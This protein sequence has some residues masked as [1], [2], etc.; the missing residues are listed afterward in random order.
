MPDKIKLQN[1][2]TFFHPK[3]EVVPTPNL[4]RGREEYNK[5]NYLDSDAKVYAES[6]SGK[7]NSTSPESDLLG[8]LGISTAA[9]A[10]KRGLS[11]L[12]NFFKKPAKNAN[13]NTENTIRTTDF[14]SNFYK[15]GYG[16][17]KEELILP[18]YAKP[19]SPINQSKQYL[20]KRMQNGGLEKVRNK[21]W[22]KES[23]SYYEFLSKPIDDTNLDLLSEIFGKDVNSVIPIKANYQAAYYGNAF[24]GATIRNKNSSLGSYNRNNRQTIISHEIGHALSGKSPKRTKIEG[25]DVG[26]TYFSRNNYDELAQR[27]L[28]IKNYFGLTNSNQEVTPSML[29]YA[30]KN[31]IKDTGIDNDMMEFFSSI[32]DFN[33]AAKWITENSYENGGK[34]K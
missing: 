25:F 32:T 14:I 15:K 6:I 24:K 17:T 10:T 20:K 26:N 16:F 33:K 27:G 30:Y 8:F 28:Q 9:Q 13:F 21:K 22:D 19:N 34:L 7:V 31:Y 1:V 3:Y 18:E 29:K 23:N 12:Y 5:G 4:G 2:G 11:R